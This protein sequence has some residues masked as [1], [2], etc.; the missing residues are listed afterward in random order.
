MRI[1]PIAC[2]LLLV[3]AGCGAAPG[4]PSPT[5]APESTQSPT[6]EAEPSPTPSA[7]V[8][9]DGNGVSIAG[10]RL[11][12]DPDP[13]F[14][15]VLNLTGTDVRPPTVYTAESADL[16]SRGAS[17][18]YASLGITPPDERVGAAGAATDPSTVYL[19][20]PVL[21]NETGV[22]RTLA[23]EF[24]HTVQYRTG[25]MD[26]L[27]SSLSAGQQ[28]TYDVRKTRSLVV[29]GAATHVEAQYRRAFMPST[30]PV[31]YAERYREATAWN[32]LVLAPYRY[33]PGYVEER[34]DDG[35]DLAAIHTDPPNST[36]QVL[37]GSDDPIAPL[38]VTADEVGEWERR[39]GA[40][41]G[42]LFVRVALRT[43]LNRS[44][45]VDAAHGWG[46]D[47]RLTYD[48]GEATATA[49]VLRWDDAENATEFETAFERYLDAKATRN[50]GVWTR[51]DGNTTYRLERVSDRN[52]V[53]YLGNES[54]VRAANVTTAAGP[55]VTIGNASA[56]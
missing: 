48:R 12:V 3:L 30:E 25:W 46:N 41:Q 38:N 32:R 24:V 34:L 56:A 2:A 51:E 18:F 28:W 15:R 49:W 29:E 33:G 1:A 36:E 40:T 35:D 21:G 31:S 53:V 13:V 19:F 42:E 7:G 26:D 10:D 11:A 23:H 55:R 37:H 39:T 4:G 43:E 44:T 17:S 22:E 50:E 54:F 27:L 20:A 8:T 45:A 14:E 9:P 6:P 47:R 16:P 5:A 52:V